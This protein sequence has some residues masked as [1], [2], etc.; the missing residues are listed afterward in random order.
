M[1]EPLS[2]SRDHP[3]DALDAAG[4]SLPTPRLRR[5]VSAARTESDRSE[6][7]KL[8]REIPNFLKLLYRLMRDARVAAV[9]K[10]IVA[11]AIG[12]VLLPMDLIPDFIPFL[13]QV[14]DLYLLA[15]VLD[16]LFNRA[17]PELLMEHW[18]GQVG[19]LERVISGLDRAGALLPDRVRELLGQRVG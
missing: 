4:R 15:L 14:D 7:G 2:P 19:T 9:D 6:V 10:A 1:A 11:A 18:E 16:R 3:D 8:I 12:Y 17:G 5:G 13:G